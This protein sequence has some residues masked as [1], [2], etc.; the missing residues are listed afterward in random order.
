MLNSGLIWGLCV[1]S[2]KF[3]NRS[4]KSCTLVRDVFINIF[5]WTGFT[6]YKTVLYFHKMC[7]ISCIV[8]RFEIIETFRNDLCKYKKISLSVV[9]YMY[10]RDDFL[11]CACI[12]NTLFLKTDS[13]GI[14]TASKSCLLV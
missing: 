13:R 11:S 9:R 1:F 4:N 10:I 12:Q 5:Y 6:V 3:Y 7:V 8:L 2:L 14:V